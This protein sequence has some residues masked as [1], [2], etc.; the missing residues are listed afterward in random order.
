MFYDSIVTLF[1]SNSLL[2]YGITH[3]SNSNKTDDIATF[4]FDIHPTNPA[5]AKVS[6]IPIP[7]GILPMWSHT[8]DE[9]KM[10]ILAF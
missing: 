4:K 1:N 10:S 3:Y 6:S 8:G 7:S 2:T 5:A 9:K